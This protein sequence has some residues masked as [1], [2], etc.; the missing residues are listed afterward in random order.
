MVIIPL[1]LSITLQ[2]DPANKQE[3]KNKFVQNIILK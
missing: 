1:L 3:K 2:S